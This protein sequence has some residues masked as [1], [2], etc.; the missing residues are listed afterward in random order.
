M[1]SLACKIKNRG[2]KINSVDPADYKN[3]LQFCI[4]VEI[5]R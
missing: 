3:I 1:F 5:G 2:H 4:M